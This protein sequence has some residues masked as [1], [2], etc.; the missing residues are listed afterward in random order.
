VPA[1][2]PSLTSLGWNERVPDFHAHGL[3]A[4]RVTQIDR[5]S[6]TVTAETGL[7]RVPNVVPEVVCGD[8][9]GVSPSEPRVILR[10][11][12]RWSLLQGASADGSS[13][14]Q[15]LVPRPRRTPGS[16]PP[17]EAG[18]SRSTTTSP[19]PTRTSPSG[20]TTSPSTAGTGPRRGCGPASRSTTSPPNT[21]SS[22]PTATTAGGRTR[23]ASGSGTP[24][25]TGSY[26][27]GHR[28]R[29]AGALRSR[30]SR[31]VCSSGAA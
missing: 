5:S 24:A 8:W 16:R 22:A 6:V 14:P 10:V 27:P 25:G 7:L 12:P 17:D 4:G 13:S 9:V 20:A 30:R 29:R 23:P 15:L 1:S 26:T 19:R 18:S 21:S 2:A 11:A 3:I 28:S 31:T